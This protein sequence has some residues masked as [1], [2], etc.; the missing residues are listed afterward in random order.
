MVHLRPSSLARF[1]CQ[2]DLSLG[3][4][5]GFARQPDPDGAG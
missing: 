4:K 1:R 5:K 2:L 3:T